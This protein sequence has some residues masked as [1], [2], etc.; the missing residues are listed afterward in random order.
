VEALF[1]DLE[2]L[3]ELEIHHN[4]GYSWTAIAHKARERGHP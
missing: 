4:R 1:A 3:A 2:D